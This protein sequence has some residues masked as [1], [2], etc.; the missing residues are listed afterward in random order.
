MAD[1]TT[2]TAP[3]AG[4]TETATQETPKKYVY[5]YSDP[6]G[7]TKE[8]RCHRID[9]DI[10]F[11]KPLPYRIHDVA[12][13]PT[14]IDPVWNQSLKGGLGDW[15]ENSGKAQSQ[16]LAK[17]QEKLD[18]VDA[19][20]KELDQKAQQFDAENTKLDEAVKTVQNSQMQGTQQ[21]AALLKAFT[22]QSK[23]LTQMISTMQENM[24]LMQKSQQTILTE[25]N[26]LKAQPTTP[27]TGEDTKPAD[28]DN[29]AN[30]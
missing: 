21:N 2:Q 30:N 23:Q 7:A 24:A 28:Q 19:K 22:T 29:K 27:S 5:Y 17:V 12:P 6:D 16:I 18:E 25:I 11:S 8:E 20:S 15:Q 10:P 9:S 26:K 14:M 13:D 4:E 1:E 3:V